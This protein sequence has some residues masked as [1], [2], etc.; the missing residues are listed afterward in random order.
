MEIAEHI[1]DVGY[2][3]FHNRRRD[4]QHLFAVHGCSGVVST[5]DVSSDVYRNISTCEV[6][7]VVEFDSAELDSPVLDCT[8]KECLPKTRYDAPFG[9][10]E[11]LTA[12]EV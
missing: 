6:Y 10:V 7:V 11:E 9:W 8:L 4:G 2:V 1:G 5:K 12:K 3:L